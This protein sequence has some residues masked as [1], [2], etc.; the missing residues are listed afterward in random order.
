MSQS[1]ID[2]IPCPVCKKEFKWIRD[3]VK[4][5]DRHNKLDPEYDK[6]VVAEEER[7]RTQKFG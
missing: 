3:L 1:T 5:I 4:H 2:L 6:S 7:Q